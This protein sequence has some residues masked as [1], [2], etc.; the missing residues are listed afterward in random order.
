MRKLARGRYLT[1][2]GRH[3]LENLSGSTDEW[4]TE[5]PPEWW[6]FPA[7]IEE[8]YGCPDALNGFGLPTRREAARYAA[9][10]PVRCVTCGGPTMPG[11]GPGEWTCT[12]D[13][14]GDE[15]TLPT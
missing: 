3:I 5:D 6:V 4:D 14:C 7:D 12:D 11:G 13:D 15:W 8:P 9:A 10:L 2:D 1:D